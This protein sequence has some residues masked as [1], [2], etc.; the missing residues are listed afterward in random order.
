MN[1]LNDLAGIIEVLR[2]NAKGRYVLSGDKITVWDDTLGPLPTPDEI[3]TARPTAQAAF[4][5]ERNNAPILA[6]IARQEAGQ[7]RAVRENALGLT[8]AN[9][10]L[11]ELDAHIAA[12]R[13]RLV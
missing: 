1:G 9:A 2:P 4:E 11:A 5:K 8:G 7:H 12:L 10:R 3:E 6:E 13:A